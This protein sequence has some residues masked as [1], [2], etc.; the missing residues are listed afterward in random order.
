M[1]L[2]IRW[3][4]DYVDTKGIEDRQFAEDVTMSG[5]KVERVTHEADTIKGVVVGKVLSIENHPNADSLVVCSVDIGSEKLTIVTGAKNL[6][7][8]DKVPVATNGSVVAGGK[9]IVTSS[10]RGVESQGMF[11]SVAELGITVNDFPYAIENGIFVIEEDCQLG[12][13]IHDAIGLNDTIVE[14]E[15]TSNRPDCLSVLGLAREV[16]AT[17]DRPF[18]AP[19]PKVEKE[20][21]NINDLLKVEVQNKELCKRYVARAVTDV[22]VGPSPRWLR[23]RLRASGVRPINNIVDITNFVMLEY[24]QPMHAFDI[25]NVE[26]RKIVVR[27]AKEGETITTLDEIER[28]L[29]PEMLVIA[30]ASKAS[31]VAGVMGGSESGINE[32]TRTVIFESANFMGSSVRKTAQKLGL[33]TESSGRFEKGLDSRVCHEAADRACQLVEMLGAGKVVGGSIDIDN[34]V[35]EEKRIPLN[36]DW[37]NNFLGINLTSDEMKSIL[38]KID[39]TIDGDDVIPPSFRIDINHKA[40][41]AEEIARFYG[42]NKIPTTPIQGACCGIVTRRQHLEKVADE[43]MLSQG[44]YEICTYTFISP[45]LLDKALIPSDSPLRNFVK[46][47]NPLGEETSVMRTTAIPSMLSTLS[48]NYNNRNPEAALYELAKEYIPHKTADELPEE[49]IAL[50]IG[51]Y[52]DDTD[53]YRLKG[54]VEAF[55]DAFSITDWD[56]EPIHNNPTFHPGRCAEFKV[57]GETIGILGEVHPTVANNFDI[58]TRAYIA[59]LDF[60]KC[61][62]LAKWGEKTYKSMPKFPAST[63]DLALLCDEDMPVLRLEK[64]IKSA[65]GEIL[66]EISLFDIYRGEQIPK[67]KKSMAFSLKLRSADHTL[68]EEELNSAMKKAM[69]KASEMGCQLRA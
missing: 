34:D 59:K 51:M 20:E 49:K 64:A 25:D 1:D 7:V 27:N 41:V 23:E 69:D 58:G 2:S 43:S 13:D 28:K 39:F 44:L 55:L 15:I 31:A 48:L 6:K 14:F 67:G 61:C 30:D 24:C 56:V 21:G 32:N 57:N 35:H 68:N 12:Q 63:R 54:V 38:R 47:L 19:V 40:D 33:R 9:E 8:G 10:L 65:V 60:D 66:E 46:I 22:K 29:S 36:H 17:Y 45:K 5:S 26:G 52:G 11:C 3:L 18:N 37:I 16:A 53:Y 50:M 42:Y 4:N 62:L